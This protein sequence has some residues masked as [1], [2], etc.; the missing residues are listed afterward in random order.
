MENQIVRMLYS[1]YKN[2]YSDCET[3][4]DSYD[5]K[6]KTIEVIVPE[7]R[8]KPSGVRGQTFKHMMFVGIENDTGRQV[9]VW[10]KA[11]CA[12]NARKQLKMYYPGI[13]F[14]N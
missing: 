11:T 6:S 8:M 10:V 2:H 1:R 13:T 3:V 5:K 4:W 12:D 7:G 9:K 14:E